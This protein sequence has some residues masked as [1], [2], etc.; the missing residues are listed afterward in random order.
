MT[1]GTSPQHAIAI[2]ARVPA[3]E[4]VDAVDSASRR[5]ALDYMALQPGEAIAGQAIDCAFIGSCTNARLSDL[6]LAARVL[7]GR[8]VKQGIRAI[9]VPGSMQVKAAAEAEGLDQVFIEAGFEWRSSGCSMCFFAGGE[10]FGFQERVVSTTNRN[11][12]SRQGPQTRT[13]LASP[14]TVAAS[15]VTGAITDPREFLAS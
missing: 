9:C 11:F 12:E 7:Q 14:A 10:H 15:A 3:E 5:K 13:H 2:S 6:R 4:G 8:R 1:W